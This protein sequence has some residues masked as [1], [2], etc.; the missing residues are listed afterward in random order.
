[1]MT[2]EGTGHLRM[3]YVVEEP[4]LQL[5]HNFLRKI[6]AFDTFAPKRFDGLTAGRFD[7]IMIRTRVVVWPPLTF[8][9]YSFAI[10]WSEESS[11]A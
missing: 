8:G 9:S 4:S 2:E 6:L 11:R 1:M 10:G 7:S 5:V 3:R